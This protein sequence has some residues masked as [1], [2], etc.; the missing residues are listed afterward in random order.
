MRFALY[1]NFTRDP[2]FKWT[3]QLIDA[4]TARGGTS[5]LPADLL[6]GYKHANLQR[7]I[8]DGVDFVI[9][10]GGDGTFLS[11]LGLTG[12]EQV[13]RVGVNLGSV[14]FLQEIMPPEINERVDDLFSGNYRLQQRVMFQAD[15]FDPVHNC[16]AKAEALNDVI[17]TR[18]VSSSI[19]KIRLFINGARVETVPGD[20]LIVA[21]PTGSTAYSLS[22]GGPIIHPDLDMM[23]ITPICPHSLHNRS[24][25]TDS[26]SVVR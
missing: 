10:L 21:T 5:Y 24:Y 15:C 20:G 14:G 16:Y 6:P 11:S 8:P 22:C 17:L 25:I 13:P 12:L 18:G 19:L 9:S 26:T 2:S 23:V 3:G 1:P 7:G 4:I